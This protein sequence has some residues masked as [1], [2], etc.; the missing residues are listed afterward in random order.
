MD[1]KEIMKA[2][3][4]RITEASETLAANS[5]GSGLGLLPSLPVFQAHDM[6]TLSLLTI[7]ALLSMTI[8]NALAP[9]FALGGTTPS[10]HSLAVSPAS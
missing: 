10:W 5:A 7:V 9:K 8:S 1:G 3:N 4:A 2:F 6:S